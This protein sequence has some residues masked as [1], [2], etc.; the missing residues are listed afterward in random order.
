[1]ARMGGRSRSPQ[2]PWAWRRT[3]LFVVA[4]C[5]GV[6]SPR[7]ARALGEQGEPID[8]SDYTLDLYEGPVLASS[9]VMGIAGAY[10]PLSNGVQGYIWN[11]AAVAV[12]QPWSQTWFDF[13]LD[14]GFTL[15]SSI[16][17]F[18]F[19]NNGDDRF[20]NEAAYFLTGGGGL[21]FG[22]LGVGVNVTLNQYRVQSRTSDQ[23]LNVNVSQLLV[24]TGY[25]FFHGQLVAGLG[26]SANAVGLT[27]E[28]GTQVASVV[29]PAGHLGVVWAPIPLPIRVGASVRASLPASATPESAPEGIEADEDGNYVTEGYVLPRTVTLPTEIHAG[30]ALSLFR[31][32]NFGWLSPRDDP[33]MTSREVRRAH[34]AELERFREERARRLDEAERA[35]AS[36]A[37]K[38]T[39][40]ASLDVAEEKL[41]EEGDARYDEA[42]ERDRQRRLRPYREMTREKILV[43]AAVKVT[44]PTVD[45]VGLESFLRQEV[46]RSGEKVTASPRL[47][48]ESEVIP[49]YLL[50]RGGSYLEPSRFRT[51]TSRF[52]GT[53]GLDVRIPI[54]WSVFGLLDDDTTFRVGGAVDGAPRYFGW[55]VSAGIWR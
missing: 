16:T 2:P 6:A 42:A 5:A 18:D 30:V 26:I 17:G 27:Q 11:P 21:L 48:V 19:D 50:L 22:N 34:E 20:A 33:H 55:A 14:G 10:V 1:M 23:G 36:E 51:G 31:R 39:L 38:E 49:G 15:P 4:L 28:D 8:T 12:R 46:E 3:G 9:R 25:A 41:S 13:D 43:S 52:H 29:G 24:V 37:A 54:E 53:G 35:G 40:E 7:S 44:L 45:G 47:G 32:M